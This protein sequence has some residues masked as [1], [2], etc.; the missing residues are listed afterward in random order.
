MALHGCPCGGQG[1][2]KCIVKS[3]DK[4]GS[5]EELTP[6]RSDWISAVP[7]AVTAALLLASPQSAIKLA[8]GGFWRASARSCEYSND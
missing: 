5:T 3:E 8:R 4:G 6:V 1:R 2:A 7:L